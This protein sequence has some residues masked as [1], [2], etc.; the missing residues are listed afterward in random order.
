[1]N[2]KNEN[3][4]KKDKIVISKILKVVPIIVLI[5]IVI[6]FA[7]I[8]NMQNRL[9]ESKKNNTDSNIQEEQNNDAEN[10]ENLYEN[11]D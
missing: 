3:R 1:M 5:V 6:T 2:N 4:N 10:I 7:M 8:L 9:S 11:L